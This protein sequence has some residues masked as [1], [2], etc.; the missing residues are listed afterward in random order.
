[1]SSNERHT[2]GKLI[3]AFLHTI[4]VRPSY[5]LRH[6][7][8]KPFSERPFSEKS[9]Y[10]HATQRAKITKKVHKPPLK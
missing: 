7:S 9:F 10:P 3:E 6:F 8:A 5:L 2:L 1:M 4:L